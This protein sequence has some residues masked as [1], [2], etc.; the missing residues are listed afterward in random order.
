[1]DICVP[2]VGEREELLD[3]CEALVM[4]FK[5]RFFVVGIN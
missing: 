4:A 2:C 5:Y 3:I 1:M